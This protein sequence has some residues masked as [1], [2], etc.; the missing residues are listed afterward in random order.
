MYV[1]IYIYIYIYSPQ[2]LPPRVPS[3]AFPSAG[4]QAAPPQAPGDIFV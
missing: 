1:N 2:A 4:T 3:T